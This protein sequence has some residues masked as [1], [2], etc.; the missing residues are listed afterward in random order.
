MKIEIKKTSLFFYNDTFSFP[1]LNNGHSQTGI[2]TP[3]YIQ[4]NKKPL[5]VTQRGAYFFSIN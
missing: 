5:F 3:F 2:Y 1:V 4:N